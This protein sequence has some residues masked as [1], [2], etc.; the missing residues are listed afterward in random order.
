MRILWQL[1]SK[2]Y[3]AGLELEDG[4]CVRAAPILKW[5]LGKGE[6]WIRHHCKKHNIQITE[7]KTDAH[8][9]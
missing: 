9:S 3:S 1:Q 4:K 6:K 2:M 8:R 5:A 7:V